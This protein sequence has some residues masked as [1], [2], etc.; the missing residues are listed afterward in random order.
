M[1]IWEAIKGRADEA[2]EGTIGVDNSERLLK[3]GKALG[4]QE[5]A[6]LYLRMRVDED[7]SG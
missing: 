5:A 4:L 3:I 2:W 1:K 7:A 6:D